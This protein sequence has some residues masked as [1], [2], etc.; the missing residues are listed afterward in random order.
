MCQF[1]DNH[2]MPIDRTLFE[3][4]ESYARD[5]LVAACAVFKD[6]DFRKPEYLVNIMRDGLKRGKMRKNRQWEWLIG[7]IRYVKKR[8]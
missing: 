1:A 3:R 8:L 2:G 4:N 6:G 7:S 5:A